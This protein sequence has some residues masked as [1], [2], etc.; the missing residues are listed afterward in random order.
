[1]PNDEGWGK[2]PVINVSWIEATAYAER[3]SKKTGHRYRLPTEAEWKYTAL[4]GTKTEHWWGEE[5]RENRANVTVH[6]PVQN[7][8]RESVANP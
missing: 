4:A 7:S 5:I 2:R 3:L 8:H 1:M 6:P